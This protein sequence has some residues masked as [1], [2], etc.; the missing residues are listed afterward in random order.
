MILLIVYTAYYFSKKNKMPNTFNLN[1]LKGRM[2]EHLV[3]D[4]FIQ[5]GY[6]VSNSCRRTM[7]RCIKVIH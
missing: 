7:V 2:A 4:L 1:T 3:Q 6:N 5:N